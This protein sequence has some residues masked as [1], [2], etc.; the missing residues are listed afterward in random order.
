MT[1]MPQLVALFNGV[2]GGAAALVAVLE[3][4]HSEDPWVRLAV[5]F[6]MLVG[7]V[8]FAGSAVTVAQA[9][10][11]D[12][13]PPPAVS[14]HAGVMA[15]RAAGRGGLRRSSSSLTG[16][17]GWADRAAGAGP[18]GRA[19]AGAARRRRRRADRD[20]AAQRLHR[21]RGGGLRRGAGQCAPARRRDARRGERNH[22]HQGDG[23]GDGARGGRH[24][25]RGVPRRLD[26]GLDH[27]RA[28]GRCGPPRPRTLPSS[29]ATPSAW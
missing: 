8:S 1:Q 12:Q 25:V 28:T 10:G 19:A 11:A 9:A 18:R 4:G 26:G 20:L 23:L 2:G 24:H 22:P 17:A 15:R 3:L 21:P 16:S 29:S 13:H 6:T 14:R 7:A 27:A 5:V